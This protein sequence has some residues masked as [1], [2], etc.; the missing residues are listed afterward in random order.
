MPR[1]WRHRTPTAN[2]AG[3]QATD[4]IHATR[5]RWRN[6]FQVPSGAH[7]VLMRPIYR[8][9]KVSSLDSGHRGWPRLSP[10]FSTV[11]PR[12]SKAWT[13]HPRLHSIGQ[14]A[15][16]WFPEKYVHVLGHDDISIHARAGCPTLR[17]FRRVGFR[18]QELRPVHFARVGTVARFTACRESP[19]PAFFPCP[20]ADPEGSRG[21]GRRR[22]RLPSSRLGL[23]ICRRSCRTPRH[24]QCR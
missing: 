1:K 5:Q 2:V 19:W 4:M 21:R 7:I 3:I 24:R 8:T 20:P 23:N 18:I 12:P 9:A 11:H 10:L 22:P 15:M 13:G 6:S 16:L 17:G 14:V